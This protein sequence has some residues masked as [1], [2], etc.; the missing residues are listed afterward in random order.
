VRST[1][2]RTPSNR[3]ART[4][5]VLLAGLW[6]TPILRSADPQETDSPIDRLK[7][8]SADARWEQVR[9]GWT[10][11]PQESPAHDGEPSADTSSSLPAEDPFASDKPWTE[12]VNRAAEPLSAG[13]TGTP[14][15]A[16]AETL[17]PSD[18]AAPPTP[19]EDDWFFGEPDGLSAVERHRSERTRQQSAGQPARD[20]LILT[21][22]EFLEERIE[23][24]AA[25]FGRH[26]TAAA[27]GTA[28][29]PETALQPPPDYIG[30]RPITS[31]QP[32]RDYDPEGGDP[33]AHLCP[34]PGNCPDNRDYLCPEEFALPES[35]S[36]DRYFG[37]LDYCWL[38]SNVHHNPLYFE[39]PALERYGHVHFS[40]CAEPLFSIGRFSAQLAAL[41]YQVALDPVWKRQYALGWY[42]PGDFAPKKVYQP[43]LNARAAATAAGVYTGLFLLVP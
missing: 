20:D 39:N 30:L 19:A 42:R 13:V 7:Q 18:E 38:A 22:P 5:G 43:P 16:R 4:V 40:D 2:W 25:V 3:F 21:L 8:R 32:F 37:H 23:T 31:I 41:P 24:H 28:Q 29:T 10:Q 15:G 35:G 6:I 27:W 12:A 34:L 17:A 11:L 14:R 36:A 1:R 33:C 9:S 26:R